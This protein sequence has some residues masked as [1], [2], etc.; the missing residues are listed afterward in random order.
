M[1][2]LRDH[3]QA[4]PGAVRG[5]EVGRLDESAVRLLDR[6]RRHAEATVLDLDGVTVRQH[7]AGD[8]HA[9]LRRGER[10]RVLQ[11]LG[12]QVD[13]VA[14]RPAEHGRRLDGADVDALV[15]LDLAD[16]AAH[17][18]DDRHGIAPAAAGRGAGQ[19]DQVLGVSP[20]AG[21][22]MVDPVQVLELIRL[23]L[24][25]FHPVE[26]RELAVQQ[27]LAAPGDV[28]EDL[29][30]AAPDVRLLH[31]GL[32]GGALHLVERPADLADLVVAVGQWRRLDVHVDSL[33]ALQPPDHGGQPLAGH[34]ER[35]AAQPGQAADDRAADLHRDD[36]RDDQRGE[37]DDAG[38]AEPDEDVDRYGLRPVGEGLGSVQLERA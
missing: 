7:L 30:D 1:R 26:Q 18:I 34:L 22:E 5:V 8:L 37:T 2:Q 16:R 17:D 3:E 38:H 21:G 12:E 20:H 24:A 11:Q 31:R 4:Q 27:R 19:D 32:Y 29:V 15:V 10:G 23:R 35:L 9:G 36:D 33:A 28:E 13:D 14:D 6:L 25:A